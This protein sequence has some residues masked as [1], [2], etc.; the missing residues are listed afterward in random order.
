M[1]SKQDG[2]WTPP[3]LDGF[4]WFL[5]TVSR[6]ARKKGGCRNALSSAA[7]AKRPRCPVPTT[8]LGFRDTEASVWLF[9]SARDSC[10]YRK[11]GSQSSIR[12][13]RYFLRGYKR[14][15]LDSVKWRN[16][17][18]ADFA[19]ARG[20]MAFLVDFALVQDS[21]HI[22]HA[23]SVYL[24]HLEADEVTK[25]M[26]LRKFEKSPRGGQWG[27]AWGPATPCYE[28]RTQEEL[29]ALAVPMCRHVSTLSHKIKQVCLHFVR[30][31]L[32]MQFLL[33]F[34]TH[35]RLTRMSDVISST[36]RTKNA[37]NT[38]AATLQ[39]PTFAYTIE[40][41]IAMKTENFTSDGDTLAPE[42][43]NKTPRVQRSRRSKS[44]PAR[45]QPRSTTNTIRGYE[46]LQR[47]EALTSSDCS[48]DYLER[49]AELSDSDSDLDNGIVVESEWLQSIILCVESPTVRNRYGA[50]SSVK[51]N[52]FA[53]PFLTREFGKQWCERLKCGARDDDTS[54]SDSLHSELSVEHRLEKK[55]E[56]KMAAM[57]KRLNSFTER[58]FSDAGS[59]TRTSTLDT[60]HRK[61]TTKNTLRSTRESAVEVDSRILNH[62][63][64]P[65]AVD[66]SWPDVD[67]CALRQRHLGRR[68]HSFTSHTT[69]TDVETQLRHQKLR[70]IRDL[71]SHPAARNHIMSIA[72]A[73]CGK[74]RASN[75]LSAYVFGELQ[76]RRVAA[77]GHHLRHPEAGDS[78]VKDTMANAEYARI[79]DVMPS[80]EMLLHNA[81]NH[82]ATMR[83]GLTIRA[84]K[85]GARR[86]EG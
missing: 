44:C 11:Q 34:A 74:K 63:K 78:V 24:V 58:S 53:M 73:N 67:D 48:S 19:D 33:I 80:T 5:V 60:K 47:L 40:N 71:P 6:D 62:R 14:G 8:I 17:D 22:Q 35:F 61:R 64:L 16:L 75:P 30:D 51:N 46:L 45:R 21:R 9:T 41:D 20:S 86:G 37:Q 79:M 68:P 18:I 32:N 26:K 27:G 12:V 83:A 69:D 76:A 85:I 25:V 4:M 7:A 23:E 59:L 2:D 81:A 82:K 39:Q 66:D 77:H 38:S 13:L 57:L 49:F 29:L 3:P 55:R 65:S 15:P 31:P 42:N 43:T 84:R 36:Q 54:S 28:R 50:R 1:E 56:A 10:C 70:L 52:N 72:I